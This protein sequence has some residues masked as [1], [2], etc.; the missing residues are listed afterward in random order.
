MNWRLDGQHALVTGGTRGIGNAVADELL[1]LGAAVT[2]VARTGEDV[3]RCVEAW[4][5][6]R[7][8]ARGIAADIATSEGRQGILRELRR[9]AP[10]LSILINNAGMNVRKKTLDYAEDEYRTIIETNMISAFEL[11]RMLH[12][13]LAERKQGAIVNVVSVAGLKHVRTGPPYAMTKAALVQ[14][15]R[16]LA[17]EW[18]PD[19]IRVNAVAPWYID[20]PMVKKVLADKEYFDEVIARTPMRRIGTPAEVAA[21]VAFLCMPGA[22]YVTGQ[23]LAVDGGFSIYGF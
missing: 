13:L 16:N 11:C 6:E 18:A 15:T 12:P 23:C 19:G 3:R 17:A 20:T 21:A 4:R 8:P 7:L 10:G 22:S 1:R 2:I 5:G 9:A 14:M